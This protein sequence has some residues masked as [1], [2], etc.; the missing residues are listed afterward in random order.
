M[1]KLYALIILLCIVYFTGG[2]IAVKLEWVTRDDYFAYAGIVGGLASVAGLLALTR[3]PITQSDF[4]H[5]ELEA[6]KSMAATAEQ[7]KELQTVHAKTVQELDGLEVKKKQMELLV[8]KA[9]LALFLKE[10]YSHHERQVL[11]EVTKNDHLRSALEKSAESAAKIAAL[12]EEIEA[13]PNVLQLRRIIDA[14]TRREPTFEEAL[15]DLT[16]IARALFIL[17]RT[18]NRSIVEAVRIISSKT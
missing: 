14:A 6:L 12:N 5:V 18:L 4:K 7:L 16:P 3:P 1:R 17:V 13:D 15:N 11:E 2:W 9:S 10:Q 8:K